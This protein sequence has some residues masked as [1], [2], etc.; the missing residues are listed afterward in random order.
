MHLPITSDLMKVP[1]LPLRPPAPHTFLALLPPNQNKRIPTLNH[2]I[3]PHQQLLHLR[4]E[5]IVLSAHC[6]LQ[7]HSLQNGNRL[8]SIQRITLADLDF[9][10]VGVEWGFE[11]RDV[12]V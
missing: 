10:N 9:P 2:I 8:I 6:D 7:F 11:F 1:L 12:G 3:R 5:H 4:P